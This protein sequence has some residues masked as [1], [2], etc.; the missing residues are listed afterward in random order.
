MEMF[1]FLLEQLGD[2]ARHRSEK[3]RSPS[4]A[5]AVELDVGQ[6]DRQAFGAADGRERRLD[7]AGNAEVAAVDVQGMGDAEL[8]QSARK[9]HDDVARRDAVIDVLLVE[10]ELAL[11]ELEGA[12]AAGIDDLDGDRLGGVH[13]P[14]DIVLDREKSFLPAIWR[15]RKSSLPSM[16]K[17]PLSMIGVSAIS[18]C[19]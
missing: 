6:M 3:W 12:D 13:R 18:M 4:V 8:V 19:A 16:T 7:V 2:A 11:V 15:R 14:G 1:G 10:I 5:V 9:R 17:A